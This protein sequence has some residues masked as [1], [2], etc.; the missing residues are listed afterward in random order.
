MLVKRLDVLTDKNQLRVE[1]VGWFGREKV[2]YMD[3]GD[4]EYVEDES[5][6]V[7]NSHLFWNHNRHYVDRYL[8]FK[9]KRTKSVLVFDKDGVWSEEGLKNPLIY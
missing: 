7:Y 8:V 2:E 5:D 3:I 4:V 9:N 6:P 1:R